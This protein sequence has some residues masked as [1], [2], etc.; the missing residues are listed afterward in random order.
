MSKTREYSLTVFANFRIDS[1]ERFLRMKDSFFSFCNASIKLWVINIRG[2]YKNLAADFLRENL[3]EKLVLFNLNSSQGWFF[4]SNHM[5]SSVN[6]D[7]VFFWNEDHICL[8]GGDHLNSVIYDMG[9]NNVDYLGYSWFGMGAYLD[10]FKGLNGL[11][12]TTLTLYEYNKS[13]NKRRQIN[14]KSI[15]GVE[16]YIVSCCGVFSNSFMMR[17][18][19]LG[20]PFPRRWPKE[21]PFDFEKNS[22]DEFILPINF[23]VPKIELFACID[24]DNRHPGSSLISRGLYPERIKRVRPNAPRKFLRLRNLLRSIPFA[25]KTWQFIIRIR[26]HF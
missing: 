25:L 7:Y 2:D 23:G 21:T 9:T 8:V 15:I 22:D 13:F 14:A 16:S 20:P 19:S 18:L 1:E 5:F 24:D 6:T 10:E 17:I 11:N 12:L 3:K 26:Y 4:D